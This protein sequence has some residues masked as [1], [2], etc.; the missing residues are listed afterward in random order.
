[1]KKFQL[2]ISILMLLISVETFSQNT[3]ISDVTNT[4][5]ASAV[6]DVYSTTKGMLTPRLTQ[7]QRTAI[8]SPATGLLVYQTDGLTGF[9]YYNGSAWTILSAG[10]V[11]WQS[12]A[13]GIFY[14][15]GFAGVGLPNPSSRLTVKDTIEIR[16][17]G[18]VANLL[19]SNT[20]GTGDFR[21]GGD[22]GDVFWQGGGGRNL[23]MGS[24]WGM[25]LTGDRQMGTPMA[26]T[27]GTGGTGV[28]V[29]AARDQSV[30][31]AIQP[32]S[33]SQTA[34]LTEWRNAAGTTLNVVAPNGNVAIGTATFDAVNPEK[35]VV[36][37]GV[38]TS[39][40]AIY[41]K[42]SVNS[43]LQ[44]NIR[45]MSSGNQ[46]SS[47]IVAT[48]N[49]GTETT[50]FVDLGING[51]GYVY[52]TGNPIETGA[53]NDGYLLSAGQDFYLVNNNSTKNMIFLVG[54][55]APTN[56]ALR[57]TPGELIGVGTTTPQ[58]KLDVAGS[59]KLGTGGTVLANVI[60]NNVTINDIT[61]FNYTSTRQITVTV[62]GATVNGTVMVSPRTA[63]PASIGIAW[64]RVSAAN[65]VT[66]AFTNTD[67]TLKTIGS[68][69]FDV[70]IIQ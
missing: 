21:I 22:G 38:T 49:N 18:G 39:V 12:T 67:T 30:P 36:D 3:G 62:T 13:N 31:L 48:A 24:F 42:G 35:L 63:L 28:L 7:A 14:N 8:S 4:P 23:Q 34:N 19:F 5:A 9:Y 52:Q 69:T 43:Y 55:T 32:N 60:K 57:I 40:N 46:S 33:G 26:F 59:F 16:R 65:T 56:E 41:A 1:M 29:K 50:N 45:N 20:S 47:D 25:V 11:Q 64:A 61:L 6:L 58:A 70:T 51:S 27:A 68:I 44:T 17:V 66:I 37:M 10:A 2:T 53:A 54:G 15:S